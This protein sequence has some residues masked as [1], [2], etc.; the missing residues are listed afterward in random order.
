MSWKNVME[1]GRVALSSR[2]RMLL[3]CV[4]M[5]DFLDLVLWYGTGVEVELI[6]NILILKKLPQLIL[7]TFFMCSRVWIWNFESKNSR[8]GIGDL[9]TQKTVKT[10]P[11]LRTLNRSQ[12]YLESNWST[13]W[14]WFCGQSTIKKRPAS[15]GPF[16][17]CL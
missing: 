5:V 3:Q 2:F 13:I 6:N 1:M 14:G 4:K 17:L 8:F 15:P 11:V 10:R 16:S 12:L 7:Y 9:E